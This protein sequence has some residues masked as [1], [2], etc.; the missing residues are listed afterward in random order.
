MDLWGRQL[1]DCIIT[2]SLFWEVA[3]T[4]DLSSC[5]YSAPFVWRIPAFDYAGATVGAV[6]AAGSQV[7]FE[8]VAPCLSLILG[9]WV[10]CCYCC[11]RLSAVSY[12]MPNYSAW[13]QTSEQGAKIACIERWLFSDIPAVHVL[14]TE[15]RPLLG[16]LRPCCGG[17]ALADV[18]LVIAWP[19]IH[20]L[21][22]HDP[23][24]RRPVL[25][26]PG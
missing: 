19:P 15:A 16:R 17:P 25:H 2:S 12:T 14:S 18:Y 3:C 4:C 10:G 26:P 21:K 24:C 11:L 22:A 5:A 20:I 23:R 9:A 7:C 13:G 8:A 6:S 1:G